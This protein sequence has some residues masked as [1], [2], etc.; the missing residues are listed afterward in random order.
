ML[1]GWL[2]T[3]LISGLVQAKAHYEVG[4]CGI[5][6]TLEQV[7]LALYSNE[8]VFLKNCSEPKLDARIRM[9]FDLLEARTQEGRTLL[10]Q[11]VTLKN[12]EAVPSQFVRELI[13]ILS[14]DKKP[15]RELGTPAVLLEHTSIKEQ[16]EE[17]AS[18]IP[19]PSEALLPLSSGSIL[20]VHQSWKIEGTSSA[21][22]ERWNDQLSTKLYPGFQLDLQFQ[23]QPRLRLNS[24]FSFGSSAFQVRQEQVWNQQYRYTFNAV[25]PFSWH[26]GVFVG[27]KLGY[28]YWGSRSRHASI[29]SFNRHD[30]QLGLEVGARIMGE[31]WEF[32]LQANALPILRGLEGSFQTRYSFVP[33]WSIILKADQI[34]IWKSKSPVTYTSIAFGLGASL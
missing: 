31:K 7:E 6:R 33:G 8:Q 30:L 23:W 19:I 28:F 18:E 1:K 13:K 29:P 12:K 3:C 15:P 34:A 27:P 24:G 5:S 2:A 9:K 14:M 22:L 32:K 25:Y 4:I 16:P 26:S 10:T 20:S 21:S 11:R 17:K